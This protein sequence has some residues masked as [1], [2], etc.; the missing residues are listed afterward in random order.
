MTLLLYLLQQAWQAVC[1]FIHDSILLSACA[2]YRQT[3]HSWSMEKEVVLH[4][5]SSM[6]PSKRLATH[7]MANEVGLQIANRANHDYK[8]SKSNGQA[9]HKVLTCN[10]VADVPQAGEDGTHC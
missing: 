7:D 8:G 9:P 10:R 5:F 3:P 2:I 6:P 1:A 4:P